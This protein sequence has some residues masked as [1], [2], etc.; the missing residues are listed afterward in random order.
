[1]EEAQ[2]ILRPMIQIRAS[3][4]A[5]VL[6]CDLAKANKILG[7]PDTRKILTTALEQSFQECVDQVLK[8]MIRVPLEIV[9]VRRDCAVKLDPLP[10]FKTSGF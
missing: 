7:Q 10:V 6:E 2:I 1:M 5:E 9:P 4:A 8:N 3:R